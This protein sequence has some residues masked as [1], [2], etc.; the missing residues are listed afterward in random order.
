VEVLDDQHRRRARAQ[1]LDQR[2][3]D[4]ERLGASGDERVRLT[5]QLGH[6][7]EKWPERPGSEQRVARPPQPANTP[8]K[9]GTKLP[10]QRRLADPRL[11]EHKQNP[12]TAVRSH[13]GGA[14]VQQT[15]LIGTLQ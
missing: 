10:Q 2:N 14:S 12:A 4:V 15:E 6:R 7:L 1:R 9:L 8:W 3:C 5:P 11:A 13:L